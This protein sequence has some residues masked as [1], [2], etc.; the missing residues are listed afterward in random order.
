VIRDAD[1]KGVGQ[2]A[3]EARDLIARTRGGSITPAE[4]EGSVVSVSNLGMFGIDR[5]TAIINPP[6][7]AILAVGRAAERAV[8]RGGEVVVREMMTLTLSVDHRAVYGA[9]GAIF[10]GR[11]A[12]LLERPGALVL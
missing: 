7:A 3:R 1:G 2:I 8:A 11:V 5:F 9:D 4:L 12:E 6:E 10:L